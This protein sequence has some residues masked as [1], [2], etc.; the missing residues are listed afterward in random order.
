MTDQKVW[1]SSRSEARL[2]PSD[3]QI[4][5]NKS[6]NKKK[7]LFRDQNLKNSF[8]IIFAIE[9][10]TYYPVTYSHW[11]FNSR[12]GQWELEIENNIK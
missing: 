9:K 11:L 3:R 8:N 2:S 12:A 7:E 10:Q 5:Q 1:W 4:S 6:W